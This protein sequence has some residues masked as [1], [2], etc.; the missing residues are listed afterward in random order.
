ML[1]IRLQR[2]GRSGHA[3][4]RVVVQDSH[5]S[6]KRGKV[7]E[8]LGSYDPHTKTVAIE[9]ERAEHFL[10]H[11][12]QPSDRVAQ[13]LKAEGV[14]LPG[15]VNLSPEK[16]KSIRNPDKLRKNRPAQPLGG[17][18]AGPAGAP[19]PEKA[20]PEAK[21]ELPPA[22]EVPAEA[23]APIMEEKADN[24]P[25]VEAK[26]EAVNS[27]EP[28]STIAKTEEKPVPPVDDQQAEP[29]KE[30]AENSEDTAPEPKA[31]A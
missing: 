21:E 7:V 30:V 3:S 16:K 14:K 10:K 9:K 2:T 8:R 5:R 23:E 25:K 4:F 26:D 1:A 15:W 28:E 17:Q 18:Q 13:L 24:E 27:D 6:P 19:E 22:D 11:G 12:A 20:K 31:S 29:A